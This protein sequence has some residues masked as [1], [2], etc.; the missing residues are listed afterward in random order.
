MFCALPSASEKPVQLGLQLSVIVCLQ[1]YGVAIANEQSNAASNS[2]GRR[3]PLIVSCCGW[4]QWTEWGSDYNRQRENELARNIALNR[5]HTITLVPL[6][7]DLLNAYKYIERGRSDD[8]QKSIRPIPNFQIW[9][10]H[11][12]EVFLSLISENHNIWTTRTLVRKP[13]L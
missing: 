3:G 6:V 4:S 2:T 10:Y 8:V 12:K 9:D 5:G 11:L 7:L 1:V 13:T